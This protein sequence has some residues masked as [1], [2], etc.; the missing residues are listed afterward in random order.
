MRVE[1]I[2]VANI[3]LSGNSAKK[4]AINTIN[5]LRNICKHRLDAIAQ[6]DPI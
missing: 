4:I 3:V 2:K 5:E 6:L 1:S